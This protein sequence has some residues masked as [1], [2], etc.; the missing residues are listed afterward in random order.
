MPRILPY[1]RISSQPVTFSLL[2]LQV[3]MMLLGHF[4][5]STLAAYNEYISNG[6]WWRFITSLFLHVDFQ[7]FLSNMICLLILGLSIE[8]YLGSIAFSIIFFTAGISGNILSY[9]IMSITYIHTG[10]SG[11]IFG[12]LGAQLFIFYSHYRDANGKELMLFFSILFILLLFTFFHSSSNPIS[13]LTGLL[14]GGI[15]APFLQNTR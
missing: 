14:I 2:F 1:I 11:S 4:F 9:L 6:E 5:F 8:K 3:F 15:L 12:L 7:H 13:H 10:A